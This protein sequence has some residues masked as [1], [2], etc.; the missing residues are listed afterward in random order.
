MCHTHLDDLVC[1]CLCE[2]FAAKHDTSCFCR[3]D[4]GQCL[5]CGCLT[6]TVRTDQCDNFSLFYMKGNSLQCLDNTIINLEIF[7]F[8]H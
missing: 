8:Q 6:G 3:D 2:V 1:R 5:Q 7:Y 4:S